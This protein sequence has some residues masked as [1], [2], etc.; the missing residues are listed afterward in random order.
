V[1]A[2]TPAVTNFALMPPSADT[3]ASLSAGL[4]MRQVEV[5]PRKQALATHHQRT[6][7]LPSRR[8]P[9]VLSNSWSA[10][11]NR[12]HGGKAADVY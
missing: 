7:D 11:G 2:I 3:A 9:T 4:L 1:T 12:H 6:R 8:C 5:L 10:K